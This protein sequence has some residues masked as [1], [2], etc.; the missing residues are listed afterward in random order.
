MRKLTFSLQILIL[1]AAPLAAAEWK[2]WLSDSSCGASNANG[3]AASRDCAERCIK[4]GATPVLVT[5]GDGKVLKLAGKVDLKAHLRHKVKIT[6]D[7]KGEIVTIKSISKA[8]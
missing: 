5:D 3:E 6:G 4:E 8:D 7:L 2:G 1:A